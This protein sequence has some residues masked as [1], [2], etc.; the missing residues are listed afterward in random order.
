MLLGMI[1]LFVLVGGFGAWAALSNIAGAVIA[2]GRIEVDQNR[3][4]VEHPEGGV[5]QTLD[6]VEGQ[7]VEAGDVLMR[8]DPSDV[9]SALSVARMR[10][11]NEWRARQA[12]LEA[13][14]DLATPRSAFPDDLLAAADADPDLAEVLEGQRNLYAARSETLAQETDQLSRRADQI[15]AQ[16]RG[17]AVAARG[18]RSS[19]ATS[20][21]RNW[22]MCRT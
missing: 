3:Q 15:R 19:S 4:A 14:R 2:S 10:R 8:L 18:A 1:T 5:V 17:I 13:E 12:R 16:I 21:R 6:V 22:S 20:C 11:L 9:A 7:L